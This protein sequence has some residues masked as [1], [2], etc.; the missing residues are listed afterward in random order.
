[1]EVEAKFS[2]STDTEVP[3]L[4][5][6]PQVEKIVSTRTHH[7]SALYFDTDDL[8]LTRSKVT[9]RRR[10]GGSDDGWHIKFPGKGGRLE[11]H[12]PI[13]GGDGVPAEIYSMVRSIARGKELVPIAQVD[14][15]RVETLLGNADGEVIAEFCDDHVTARSLI[16]DTP[17]SWREW[18]LEIT[19]EAPAKFIAGATP[20][21]KQAGAAASKSPSKLAMALG[22]DLP[23]EPASVDI[24]PNSPAAGVLAA[25]KRNRD[26]LLAY[27]PRVRQD[28][29]DSIHQMRVATRELRSHL[30]SFAGILA[31]N[32]H[33]NV[34]EQL[35]QLATILGVA[36]DAEVIAER[37]KDL[38]EQHPSGIINEENTKQ[39]YDSMIAEYG[40]AHQRVVV[41]LNDDKYLQL[42]NELD[43]LISHPELAE[44][45]DTP[46]AESVLVSHLADSFKVLAKRHKKAMK[47]WDGHS[48]LRPQQEQKFHNVRKA[49]K[50]LRYTTEA[51]GDATDIDT[52]ELYQAC[53]AL[54]EV[55]GD[56]QDSVTSREKLVKKSDQAFQR[57][58]NTFIYGVLYETEVELSRQILQDY[59]AAFSAVSRAYKQLQQ[60]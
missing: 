30:Q 26:K 15:E 3:D 53:K 23:T 16:S 47:A 57:G 24:D 20:T 22:A 1:M 39:L 37:F 38:C 8:R 56:F 7:L 40:A 4:L 9:V 5:E 60:E 54:Q 49:T 50:K 21:L 31:G 52:T 55:L 17:T 43:D 41:A 58:E 12:H 59:P 28:E 13:V 32:Q 27:D 34:E 10:T 45:E 51:V 36:R 42:L 6:I 25:L 18:E 48:A 44:T 11:V 14:N 2:V 29:W 19:P 33:K 35:K 46:P